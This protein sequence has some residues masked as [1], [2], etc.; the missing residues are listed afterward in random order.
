MTGPEHYRRAEQMVD[1][2]DQ[3]DSSS[4]SH[5]PLISLLLAEAQVHATLATAAAT[6][7]NDAGGGLGVPDYD[8]WHDVASLSRSRPDE[9][10]AT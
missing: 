9:E 10:T 6:A 4:K 5:Q 1:G 8:A 2:I 3:L 7:L